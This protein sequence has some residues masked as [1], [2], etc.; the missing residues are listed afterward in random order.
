[1]IIRIMTKERISDKEFL[2]MEFDYELNK[3]LLDCREHLPLIVCSLIDE[4]IDCADNFEYDIRELE[5]VRS[6]IAHWKVARFFLEIIED[7]K[8]GYPVTYGI[9]DSDVDETLRIMTVNEVPVIKL[10]GDF[11]F[12]ILP[13]KS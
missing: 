8:K 5:I 7:I 10:K 1:M 12:K 11:R 13:K 9:K 4:L 3:K 2:E 6:E